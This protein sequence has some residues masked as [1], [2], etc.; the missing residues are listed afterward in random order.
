MPINENGA[1]VTMRVHLWLEKGNGLCFGLGRA[2]LLSRIGEHGSLKKAAEEMSMSYRAAWGKIKKSEETLGIEL[3]AR[4][5]GR[6][7]GYRLTAAGE[8]LT[9]KYMAWYREV[10]TVALG[11]A[12]DMLPLP[13]KSFGVSGEDDTGEAGFPDRLE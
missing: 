1:P 5:S 10:E 4:T 7:G 11:L 13:I 12:R 8:A 6:K 3:I 2:M 9:E